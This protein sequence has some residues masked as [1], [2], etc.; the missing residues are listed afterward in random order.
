M[1]WATDS[2]SKNPM[3]WAAILILF[4][5]V[6][7]G[8][9]LGCA[10]RNPFLRDEPPLLGTSTAPS[11]RTAK[12]ASRPPRPSNDL[13]AESFGRTQ[14]RPGPGPG[15]SSTPDPAALSRTGDDD[16]PKEPASSASNPNEPA[17]TDENSVN[18]TGLSTI[19]GA[20]N[21]LN[22]NLQPPVT[23]RPAP[24]PETPPAADVE[25]V[26]AG[27]QERLA[28]FQSYQ[29]GINRQ[30]R[31]GE[32]LQAPEDIILS[33]RRNPR[34]VRLQWTKAPNQGREVIYSVQ[35]T[36]GLIEVNT[37]NALIPIPRISLPPDSPLAL[38]NSRHPITEAGFETI[39]DKLAQTLEQNRTGRSPEGQLTY[40]GLA[41]PEPL[42]R[43]CHKLIRITPTGENWQVFLDPESKLPVLVQGQAANGDLL[44]RYY[45][46]D[47]Q[48]NPDELAAA[49]AF[50]PNR[51]WGPPRGLLNR[52]AR[53]PEATAPGATRTR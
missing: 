37:P 46:H 27:A 30:E 38:R 51:R 28:T 5:L 33:I 39:V 24:R 6:A 36:K 4:G 22:V 1:D 23:L 29:V 17:P 31:V 43:P 3:H 21:S 11:T 2:A 44:E 16:R 9:A 45:F 18:R 26:V 49:D 10:G 13:F 50:D 35:E 12:A 47:F 15:S 32:V 34:A 41:Q 19:P 52:L 40:A 20:G 7:G 25:S 8:G 14:P 53:T 42:D 48:A